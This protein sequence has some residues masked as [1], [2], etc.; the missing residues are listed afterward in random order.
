[1]RLVDDQLRISATDVSGFLS[2]KHLTLLGL[3]KAR[4]VEGLPKQSAGYGALK[5]LE[6][7]GMEHEQRVLERYEAEGWRVTKVSKVGTDDD[8]VRDTREA[9]AAKPDVIYQGAL[10]AERQFGLPD[11]LIR[12]ALL[13]AEADPAAYEVVD[14]KLA[15]SAKAAAVLQTTFYS[16]LLTEL[17]GIAP[18]SMHLELGSGQRETLRVADFSSYET[19]T[20]ARVWELL[21]SAEPLFPIEAPYPEKVEHC[22][23]CSW[24]AVCR[25]RRREDDDLSRV[26]G[27]A[28]KHRLLLKDQGIRTRTAL[29]DLHPA[30]EINGIRRDTL[31]RL[32]LQALAQTKTTDERS[33]YWELA[34]DDEELQERLAQAL[35]HHDPDADRRE[36]LRGLFALPAPSRGDIFFD[37]EAARFYGGAEA[38]F[39]L[40]YLFGLVDAWETGEPTYS[41]RWAYDRNDERAVFE[42]FVQLVYD[43]WSADPNMHV[44]HYNH[45]EPTAMDRLAER[46]QT[47]AEM[48]G[49]LMGRFATKEEE[50]DQLLRN[51]VFVDLYPI[52]RQSIRAGIES[53]SLKQTE[54]VAGYRREQ[55]LDEADEHMLVFQ[56]SLEASAEQARAATKAQQVIAAYN[57]DDCRA[58]LHLRDWL[59]ERRTDLA[60]SLGAEIPRPP[61]VKIEVKPPTDLEQLKETLRTPDDD[62]PGA[63]N[64]AGA[65]LANLL[66]FQ[67]RDEKPAWWEYFH[68]RQ[69]DEDELFASRH[70]LAGLDYLGPQFDAADQR[71]K[72][73]NR[74]LHR[75]RFPPQ[76]QDF[77]A[78]DKL[79]DPREFRIEKTTDDE[80]MPRTNLKDGRPWEIREIDDT[81]GITVM[82]A[83]IDD[84]EVPPTSLVTGTPGMP[85]QPSNSL[86]RLA[87]SVR[88]N[89]ILSTRMAG[90]HLLIGSD[91]QMHDGSPLPTA[92]EPVSRFAVQVSRELGATYL[93]IQGPPGTGKTYTGAEIAIDLIS[94]VPARTI[95]VTGP[96]HQAVRNFLQELGRRREAHGL[97]FSIGQYASK[98][99]EDELWEDADVKFTDHAEA[100][101]AITD[102]SIQVLG[103]TV[104]LWSPVDAEAS[105]DTLL[106]DEAGQVSLAYAVAASAAARESL[107]LL[108]DPQQLAQVSQGIHPEGA[109]A[110]ALEHV[111]RGERVMPEARGLF[112]DRTRRMHD[113]IT[114]FVSDAFYLGKLGVDPDLH[115]DR[116]EILGPGEPAGSGVRVFDVNHA[117]NDSDSPEEAKVVAELVEGLIGRLWVDNEGVERPMTADDVMIVTPYNAQIREV[118]NALERANLHGVPVGTV[119]RFQG[120]EAAI[121]IYTTATSSADL[122]PRGMEFLYQ[123][124]RLNVAVSRAR[125]M[126]IVVMNPELIRV[127]CK[128]PRQM[129]LANALCLLRER[130]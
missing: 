103:G 13:D 16:R 126:A 66:D 8:R 107:I 7:R 71:A 80:G 64:R 40:E 1:M 113:R 117:G 56:R 47:M 30:Q 83:S 53:Y 15:H 37:L 31:T 22:A 72:Y 110:S 49:G 3:A 33:P 75:F 44:Y 127:D 36:P 119:D 85:R 58:T 77:D 41:A 74:F 79:H 78:G 106:I 39:G 65:L 48:L 82:A 87:E 62:D 51:R 42:W 11:F 46:H 91:P 96:S 34:A 122:A 10:Q 54:K 121:V 109:G 124:N 81:T 90:T 111:L 88:D 128:T 102:G 98:G 105:V 99:R 9:V 123:L 97:G 70:A 12:A 50:T 130:C 18:A 19:A 67:S 104:W 118:R 60:V 55:L 116:Q 59:E 35:A 57:E 69:V 112:I 38:G 21:D 6:Q 120:G 27:A 129:Q 61:L 23:I 45:Y 94:G 125:A 92:E 101:T 20:I 95:G 76:D 4:A 114:S 2:C 5:D 25:T 32:R 86:L 108:G 24:R 28:R 89:G 115:L 52:F 73:K 93:P 26:A 43:R 14:A 68:L 84:L 63:W 100:I 17:T 29:A